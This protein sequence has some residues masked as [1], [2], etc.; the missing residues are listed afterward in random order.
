MTKKKFFYLI[1]L[2]LLII[3]F[4]IAIIQQTENKSL[5][6]EAA[7]SAKSGWQWLKNY[8][9]KFL[10]PGN[11]LIIKIINEKYCGTIPEIE[12]FWEEILPEFTSHYY[13]A[14]F[15]RFFDTN[16]EYKM[17][18]KVLEILKTPQE[19]YNDALPQA[20]YCDLYPAR[21]DFAEKTFN[22]VDKESGYNLTHKFW[23]AILFK[24][25][26]C[27]VENYNIDNVILAAAQKIY[28]EQEKSDF[29]D[30]YA[31]R[32]AF[33][34]NYGFKKMVPEDWIKNIIKNQNKSGAWGTPTYFSRNFEN[35]HT[36]ALAI[37]SLVQYSETC[38]F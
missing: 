5:Q 1:F 23:S 28:E 14:V 12:S 13:L 35:P 4:I 7:K 36:T 16:P 34:M 18:N 30:L 37:W 17:S 24:N 27:L 9:G 32:T 11:L 3:I 19:Y 15:E 38:P 21:D 31:E 29:D 33:L 22:D 6:E 10:D 8:N 26:G 25:N 20:L 2:V